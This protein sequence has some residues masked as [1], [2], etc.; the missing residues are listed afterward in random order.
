[1]QIENQN[2]KPEIDVLDVIP[3]TNIVARAGDSMPPLRHRAVRAVAREVQPNTNG[4]SMKDLALLWKIHRHIH[5]NESGEY[6]V[7]E[8]DHLVWYTGRPSK[9]GRQFLVLRWS[10]S[11]TGT[12]FE[13]EVKWS[14]SPPMRPKLERP[15]PPGASLLLSSH[16]IDR[17]VERGGRHMPRPALAINLQSKFT[18]AQTR[19]DLVP[20]SYYVDQAARKVRLQYMLNNAEGNICTLRLLTTGDFVHSTTITQEMAHSLVT[21]TNPRITTTR[22]WDNDGS[23]APGVCA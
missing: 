18:L 16:A 5:C 2:C 22:N 15:L 8:G 14:T 4:K 1:M 23:G 12:P 17:A 11:N 7:V 3:A 21:L 6:F 13:G 9:N 20:C 19:G 10:L